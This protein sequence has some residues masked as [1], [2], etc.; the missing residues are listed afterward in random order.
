MKIRNLLEKAVKRRNGLSNI[1]DAMRLVNGEA[2]G[3]EGTTVDRYNRHFVIQKFISKS[4]ADINI[5][6]DFI[7]EEFNPEYII[8]K[9]RKIFSQ[10]NAGGFTAKV[11]AGEA[12]P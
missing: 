6:K 2:D 7:T 3:L 8:L 9:E 5:I 1:T 11:L 4:E 10:G 12:G